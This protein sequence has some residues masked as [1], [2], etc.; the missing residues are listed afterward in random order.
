M[1]SK[2]KFL[3]IGVGNEFRGDDGVGPFV[4]QALQAKLLP[5]TTVTRASGE[6]ASLM[7]L[8]DSMDTVFVIDAVSSDGEPGIRHR[9]E[10]HAETV[11]SRFFN[12]STHAFSLGEA[13]ELSRLLGTLPQRLVV[14][15]IEGANFEA[16]VGLS[17]A[18]KAAA[19]QVIQDIIAEVMVEDIQ[20]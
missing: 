20:V 3:V 6:G 11:P 10:A 15:G 12:Y 17:G 16:G 1:S 7:H 9:F 13:V 4:A 14:F 2:P 5:N 8:W 19:Y 18:V